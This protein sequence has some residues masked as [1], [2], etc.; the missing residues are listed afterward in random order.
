MVFALNAEWPEAVL[1]E[2]VVFAYKD[3]NPEPVLAVPVV[4]E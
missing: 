1:A 3:L 4:F 2:P